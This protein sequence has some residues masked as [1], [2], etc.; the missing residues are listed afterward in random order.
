MQVTA[1]DIAGIEALPGL[2]RNDRALIE[3]LSPRRRSAS[4]QVR[5]SGEPYIGVRHRAILADMSSTRRQSLL[6]CCMMSWKTP[7]S[8]ED[9]A[10]I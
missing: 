1:V 4:R 9:I 6:P 7:A 8:L 2:S 5:K 10:A 3:R